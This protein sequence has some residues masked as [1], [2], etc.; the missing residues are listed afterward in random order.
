MVGDDDERVLNA[1]YRKRCANS[2]LASRHESQ[3][4]E[5]KR[6]TSCARCW[7]AVLGGARCASNDGCG[8]TA[9]DRTLVGQRHTIDAHRRHVVELQ[10][11]GAA[12]RA[13][14]PA[15]WRPLER[16][17]RSGRMQ[18]AH[19]F[20]LAVGARQLWQAP[21]TVQVD[22]AVADPHAGAGRSAA[23]S[24]AMV[25]PMRERSR[26]ARPRRADA[27]WLAAAARARGRRSARVASRP[28]GRSTRGPRTRPTHVRPCRRRC[29][30]AAAR[31]RCPQ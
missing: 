18:R 9:H 22:A 10:R 4:L 25:V 3:V 1:S 27:G 5:N 21:R 8:P 20:D 23:N 16:G 12:Q 19:G 13:H 14:D 2:V 26:G 15:R 6:E 7:R 11:V 31:G 29:L 28:A 30:A 17:V 24:A